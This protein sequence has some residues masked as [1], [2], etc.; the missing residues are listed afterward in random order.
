[1]EKQYVW[2]LDI[3]IETKHISSIRVFND[4]QKVTAVANAVLQENHS[5]SNPWKRSLGME[6]HYYRRVPSTDSGRESV[7]I[8]MYEVE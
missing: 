6:W 8:T 1:M 4:Q 2:I 3:N 5:D 7:T